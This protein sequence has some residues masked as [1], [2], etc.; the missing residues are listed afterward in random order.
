MVPWS[1]C[2]FL[3]KTNINHVAYSFNFNLLVQVQIYKITSPAYLQQT[4]HLPNCNDHYV[5]IKKKKKNV[6]KGVDNVQYKKRQTRSLRAS[7]GISTSTFFTVFIIYTTWKPKI[8]TLFPKCFASRSFFVTFFFF[9]N[10]Y[11]CSCFSPMATAVQSVFFFQTN[12]FDFHKSFACR[13][14]KIDAEDIV[15]VVILYMYIPRSPRHP[16]DPEGQDG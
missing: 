3:T 2:I 5:T 10:F 8:I 15:I 7:C 12:R 13:I 9:S 4:S 11:P 16:L 14:K 1:I 6:I